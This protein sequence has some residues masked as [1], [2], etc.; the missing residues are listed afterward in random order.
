M[1]RFNS[2]FLAVSATVALSACGSK[3]AAG[4]T[5][6]S[7]YNLDLLISSVGV[8][9][10]CEDAGSNPGEWAWRIDVRTPTRFTWASTDNYPSASGAVS[11]FDNSVYTINQV[12]RFTD[13]PEAD[14][15]Q[16]TIT[17]R[18][19]EWDGDTPDP[20][21]NGRSPTRSGSGDALALHRKHPVP[22]AYEKMSA[23]AAALH[24]LG[25]LEDADRWFRDALAT[26][27]RERPHSL[28]DRGV[29]QWQ[30]RPAPAGSRRRD[31]IGSPAPGGVRGDSEVSARRAS[32]RGPPGTGAGQVAHAHWE[33]RGGGTAF[34]RGRSSNWPPCTERRTRCGSRC[35]TR[36]STS[37][38]RGAARPGREVPARAGVGQRTAI[39]RRPA[40]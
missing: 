38:R 5:P 34:D 25:R 16:V 14:T 4:P 1:T 24:A 8:S 39:G 20:D 9:D 11:W 23:H 18:A 28:L 29:I 15:R 3:S 26:I 31:A 13:I 17:L 37:M 36:S 30:V 2:L 33:V 21:M 10:N 40:D 27:Q 22:W 19:T 6:L 35:S 12:L 32:S 7:T